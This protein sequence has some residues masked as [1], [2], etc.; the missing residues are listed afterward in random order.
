MTNFVFLSVQDGDTF[1]I[2]VFDVNNTLGKRMPVR[3]RGIDAPELRDKRPAIKEKAKKS[4]AELENIL[5]KGDVVFYNV[6]R[7]KY[8]RLLADVRVGKT[9][10]A[11]YM[12]RKKLAKPYD[13]KKKPKW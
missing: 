5:S 11:T 13:G 3:I 9:D 1:Y 2:N 4:K 12:I 8:F 7:D 6:G 10:V